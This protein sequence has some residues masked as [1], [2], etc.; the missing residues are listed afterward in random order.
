MPGDDGDVEV[1]LV[2]VDEI[3]AWEASR[4]VTFLRSGDL[5]PALLDFRRQEWDRGR[6]WGAVSDGRFVGSLR[7]LAH[8]LSVPGWGGTTREVTVDALTNVAVSATH[9]RRGLLRRMLSAS[10]A[11]ATERGDAMSILIAAEWPIYGRFGYAPASQWAQFTLDSRRAGARLL[12]PPTGVLRATD[13]AES[14][15]V[16]GPV[17]DRARLDRAG[18]ID[19]DQRWWKRA[20]D[21]T[22]R[23]PG[24]KGANV[25]LH[26]GD[27][28]VDGFVQWHPTKDFEFEHGG[29][30][31]V[32]GLFAA[33]QNAYSALWG[34]LLSM[35]VVDRVKAYGRALDEPLPHLLADGRAVQISGLM[36]A[37]WVRLLDVP[38]ALA[39]RRYR[40]DGSLNLEVVDGDLG[41]DVSGRYRLD[42]GPGG[43]SCRRDKT[44]EPDLRLSQRALAAVYLGGPSVRAQ[45]SA[46]LVDEVR[47]GAIARADAMFGTDLLPWSATGF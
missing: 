1:R 31:E 30:I 3:P 17:F 7:T 21:P 14:A 39:A 32:D 20:L 29:E 45:H 26:E 19:R 23:F 47:P 28:G 11:A 42:G 37:V 2:D 18:Q 33:D 8:Q 9:R 15:S 34:Y 6:S 24:E 27:D 35:D 22:L 40:V 46:D 38:A 36:D 12:R 5:P 13:S 41:G 4:A 10:L 44:A 16:L 43:A 25:V